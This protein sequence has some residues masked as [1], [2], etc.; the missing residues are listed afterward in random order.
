MI[1]YF[2]LYS[3]IIIIFDNPIE[4][5]RKLLGMYRLIEYISFMYHNRR[6]I[7]NSTIYELLNISFE[8]MF[9]FG[10]MTR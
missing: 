1:F 8:H 7:H 3:L 10:K 6:N 2:I 9:Q 4:I 5:N